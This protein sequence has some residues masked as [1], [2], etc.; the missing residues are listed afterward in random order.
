MGASFTVVSNFP[1]KAKVA[2]P[3]ACTAS[4]SLKILLLMNLEDRQ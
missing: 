1:N 4:H 2:L 3:I